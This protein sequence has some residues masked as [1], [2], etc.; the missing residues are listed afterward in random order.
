M[1]NSKNRQDPRTRRVIQLSSQID[2]C[3][4]GKKKT[5]KACGLGDLER[6]TLDIGPLDTCQEKEKNSKSFTKQKSSQSTGWCLGRL[7]LDGLLTGWNTYSIVACVRK[8]A[9]QQKILATHLSC[10]RRADSSLPDPMAYK[11]AWNKGGIFYLAF[12][13][14]SLY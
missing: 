6:A 13:L 2:Y 9:H 3:A 5:I 11:V 7:H 10:K 14:S 4:S 8:T 12:C 1:S